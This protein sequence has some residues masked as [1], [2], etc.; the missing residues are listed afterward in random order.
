MLNED[1]I[2]CLQLFRNL[3]K[4]PL[5]VNNWWNLFVSLYMEGLTDSEIIEKIEN[6]DTVRKFSGFRPAHCP[7]GAKRSAHKLGKAFDIKG[8]SFEYESVIKENVKQFL[9]MGL[10]RIENPKITRGWLHMDTEERNHQKGAIR[11][12]NLSSHAYNIT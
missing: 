2:N 10:K 4:K 6:S 3:Y 11:V 8:D 9:T 1:A 12:I 5:T 7:I